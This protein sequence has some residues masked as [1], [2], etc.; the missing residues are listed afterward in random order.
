MP[1]R[2]PRS[3]RHL[4]C[5]A[6]KLASDAFRRY[7][8]LDYA[9]YATKERLIDESL[10]AARNTIAHGQYL[11]PDLE[12]FL[13]LYVEVLAL[14]EIFRTQVDNAVS[15]GAYRSAWRLSRA[16]REQLSSAGML[17]S[18]WEWWP[19]RELPEPGTL[20]VFKALSSSIPRLREYSFFSD[21]CR[22]REPRSA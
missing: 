9:P 3:A 13:E 5:L 2:R 6:N 22:H 14:F 18:R 20:R 10:V 15:S 4:L 17:L 16:A 1:V 8:S 7:D 11:C 19:P 21:D 12:D